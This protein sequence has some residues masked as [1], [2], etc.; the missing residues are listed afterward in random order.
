MLVKIKMPDVTYTVNCPQVELKPSEIQPAD[1]LFPAD[2]LTAL[3]CVSVEGKVRGWIHK[4]D[5]SQH[6]GKITYK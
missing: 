5:V 3:V 2:G 4:S 6:A 1:L